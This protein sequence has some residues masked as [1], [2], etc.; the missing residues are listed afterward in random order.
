LTT[1]INSEYY[2]KK[3]KKLKEQDD[4]KTKTILTLYEHIKKQAG[5]KGS[6]TNE[7]E[8]LTD[9]MVA[10]DAQIKELGTSHASEIKSLNT[11]FGG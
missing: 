7:I 8:T 11:K 5:D 3:F 2:E 1:Q 4:A 9:M 6:Q 10:K